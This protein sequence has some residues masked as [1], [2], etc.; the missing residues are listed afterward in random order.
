[1]NE[2]ITFYGSFEEMMEDLGRAMKEADARVRPTQANMEPGK[3]FINFRHG[4]EL[5]I[6]GQVLDYKKLGVNPEEQ[7]YINETYEQPQMKYYKPTRA[8]SDACPQ[9]ELG[10]LHLSEVDAIIDPE[11]FE[12]YQEHNWRPPSRREKH[13]KRAQYLMH[14]LEPLTQHPDLWF[15]PYAYNPIIDSL[16]IE[17]MP[18]VR[19]N[20]A[21]TAY[22]FSKM[23]NMKYDQPS[24]AYRID[25]Q[26][27]VSYSGLVWVRYICDFVDNSKLVFHILSEQPSH[28]E[29]E[30]Q[31]G[32]FY[33]LFRE[34]DGLEPIE[35]FKKFR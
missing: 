4:P 35:V 22:R 25:G 30:E 26:P 20:W 21:E 31:L 7:G 27:R 12:Y 8:F 2:D 1:M 5:P 16:S 17:V 13:R 23:G 9:G 29:A 19:V 32:R 28:E 34:R 14:E 10:D 11:L 18:Q 15:Y 33:G 3:Y 6:F 24:N